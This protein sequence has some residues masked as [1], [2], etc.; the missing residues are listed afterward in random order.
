ME[1]EVSSQQLGHLGV[2]AAI[3]QDLDL[4]KKID[5]RLPIKGNGSIV[6]MGQRVAAMILNGLGFIDERLYLQSSFFEHKPINRLLGSEISAENLNDDALARSLD[7][8]YSYGTTKLFSEIAFEVAIEQNLLGSSANT[9][10]TSL[11][12]Y[13][14]YDMEEP[15]LGY[16]C[17]TRSAETAT[18]P[19]E[20]DKIP[21]GAIIA[22][23]KDQILT[24]I[25]VV[26]GVIVNRSFPAAEVK[27][28]I[29][30]LP[31]VDSTSLDK[32]LIKAIIS[33]YNFIQELSKAP[34]NVTYGHSK[35]KRFDLKQVILSLTT[36]GPAGIPI[37]M[38]GL[39]GNSSD[40]TNL[41]ATIAKIKSFTS[42]LKECPDFIHVADSALYGK[43][44]FSMPGLRWLTRVPASINEVKQLCE[45]GL[46]E[47]KWQKLDDN[48]SSYDLISNYGDTEQRWQLIF[49]QHA[50]NKE[51]KSL[52]ERIKKEHELVLRLIKATSKKTFVTEIEANLELK[53]IQKMSKF[54]DL[55]VHITPVTKYSKKG[56]PTKSDIAEVVGYRIAISIKQNNTKID[57]AIR[58]LGK[59]VLATNELDEKI[60][61]STK[62]LAEYKEQSKTESGF[63]FIKNREF[64]A[65]T[66]FV[67]K[68]ERIEAIMVIMTL[69]L[70]VYNFGQYKLRTALQKNKETI[71]NQVKKQT[72]K[73]TLRWAFKILEKIHIVY[74]ANKQIICN[75]CDACK[76]IIRAL[77]SNAIQIYGLALNT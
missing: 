54:H 24:A 67:K 44:L 52:E 75:M 18:I 69:C 17:I 76:K 33:K 3:I 12:V 10:T 50:Y 40:K 22:Q 43:K 13:G 45:L 20:L 53:L 11:M 7:K 4:I 8:I 27:D 25:C 55:T 23:L 36:S 47:P 9:D 14:D 60:L 29:A 2:V 26:D 16:Y 70:M 65:S 15:E 58:R 37:F 19:V 63:R 49:S 66:L 32:N 34:I 64:I 61:P 59:F 46:E 35:Q 6:S 1:E 74:I 31:E 51:K 38:E 56:K 72:S 28:I 42:A 41:Q 68:P 57:L 30:S 39:S 77:G 73:P 48:Y 71:P 62:L 21:T 5:K